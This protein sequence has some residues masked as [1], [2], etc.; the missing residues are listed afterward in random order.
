MPFPPVSLLD[1]FNRPDDASLGA[2]WSEGVQG[3]GTNA[4]IVSNACSTTAVGAGSI[5]AY[6]GFQ[7]AVFAERVTVSIASSQPDG[8]GLSVTSVANT[9]QGYTIETS[10]N[11]ADLIFHLY[12]DDSINLSN[13]TATGLGNPTAGDFYGLVISDN[14]TTASI[15]MWWNKTG[16]WNL[17]GSFAATG[18]NYR[19]GPYYPGL[20]V[21]YTDQA[22]D[23]FEAG[24]GQT[25]SDDPPIGFLGRGAGW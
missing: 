15:D 23:D 8:M 20:R 3:S 19:A 5:C 22:L 18:A 14:G 7:A 9:A 2:P 10:T 1:D 6:T 16:L 17:I 12:A 25:A 11:G 13:P 21:K 4:A 24:L